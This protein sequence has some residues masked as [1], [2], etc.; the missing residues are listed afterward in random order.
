MIRKT[1]SL[2]IVLIAVVLSF[3]IG[4]WSYTTAISKQNEDIKLYYCHYI[5][6][7]FTIFILF[8]FSICFNNLIFFDAYWSL[9]PAYRT[10]RYF[11]IFYF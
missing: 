8:I 3:E 5:M 10:F 11:Q 9:M 2:L 4:W 1:F 7:I 6:E